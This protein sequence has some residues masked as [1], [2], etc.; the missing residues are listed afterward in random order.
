[1]SC[2]YCVAWSKTPWF[3]A[4]NLP[5]HLKC[6]SH[7]KSVGEEQVRQ[8]TRERLDRLRAEDLERL[9]QPAYQYAQLSRPNQ[10]EVPVPVAPPPDVNEQRMWDDFDFDQSDESL[11]H[12]N[13]VDP[14]GR[15]EAEFYRTLDGASMDYDL[16]GKGFEEFDIVQDTDETLTNIMGDPGQSKAP[17]RCDGI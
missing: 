9:R 5:Q 1:M 10:P 7:I 4:K 2:N 8:E 12:I 16:A 14:A 13:P 15:E 17:L 3:L 6:A 11:R